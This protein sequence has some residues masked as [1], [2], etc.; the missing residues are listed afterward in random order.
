MILNTANQGQYNLLLQR[1]DLP[2]P[3]T[4]ALRNAQL[5]TEYAE[6]F[7]LKDTDMSCDFFE[8]CDKALLMLGDV[9]TGMGEKLDFN[10]IIPM[11]YKFWLYNH[12][13]EG[14]LKDKDDEFFLL[15]DI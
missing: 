11:V 2:E 15:I 3:Y 4:K 5:F 14:W 13:F 1:T 9:V 10:A 7:F 6:N 8:S 12:E